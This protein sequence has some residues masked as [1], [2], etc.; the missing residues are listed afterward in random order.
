MITKLIRLYGIVQGVGFRPFVNR[1][2]DRYQISGSVCNKGSYV[3]IA[4]SATVDVIDE[5]IHALEAEAP[6]RS[7]IVKVKVKTLEPENGA[8]A[9]ELITGQRG[10]AKNSSAGSGFKILESKHEEGQIFVSPDIAICPDCARELYN[11]DDRRY[12]H[13][14]INCTQCGPR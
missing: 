2:A 12:L 4:A 8:P 13:P 7:A 11:P 10:A 6:E 9:P 3:E 14:F 1:L 5:F